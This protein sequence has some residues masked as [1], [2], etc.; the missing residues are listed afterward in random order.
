MMTAVAMLSR[1]G[2]RR[3]VRDNDDG[4]EEVVE[5]DDSNKTVVASGGG[6]RR[7]GGF[8]ES[9][10]RMARPTAPTG[11]MGAVTKKSTKTCHPPPRHRIDGDSG[12]DCRDNDDGRGGG[13]D[14]GSEND[15]SGRDGDHD[16]DVLPSSSCSYRPSFSS[17]D[18]PAPSL[19]GVAGG[20]GGRVVRGSDGN[21]QDDMAVLPRWRLD[22]GNAK[23]HGANAV[24]GGVVI[25]KLNPSLIYY[26]HYD[27]YLH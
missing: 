11:Q 16:D 5:V 21:D 7:K 22:A 14:G 10:R 18:P 1:E 3:G 12:V 25:D 8:E 13:G 17:A 27:F 26:L 19:P 4:E 23:A 2:R 24:A 6:G 20:G 9:L 15:D